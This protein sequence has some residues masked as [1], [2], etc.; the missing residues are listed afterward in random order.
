[1]K[2]AGAV[3]AAL[4]TGGYAGW[5]SAASPVPAAKGYGLDPRLIDAKAPWPRTLTPGQR[6]AVSALCDFILPAEGT[7]P[8]A[9][10]IGVH[11]LIDEWVSA[12]YPEQVADR[13]LFLS[14]LDWMDA[15]AGGRFAAATP[16]ARS[17]V[18]EAVP[19]AAAPAGF[20]ARFRRIVIGAYY[21]T[22]AGFADIGYIGNQ[23]L[24]AYPPPSAEVIAALE[25]AYRQLG[26]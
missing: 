18:L 26:I 19:A 7:A 2:W 10:A 20:Y 25:K 13:A 15:K 6:A 9:S 3:A 11:E 8:S 12:P 4:G 17:A 14:G 23:T 1:M 16:A 24:A 22:E 21:T 5:A